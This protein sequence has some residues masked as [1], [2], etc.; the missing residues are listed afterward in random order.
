MNQLSVL[1]K[2]ASSLCNMRCR[3]CFYEDEAAHREVASYG[4]MENKVV[5]C[6]LMRIRNHFSAPSHINF[7]FQGGEPTLAGLDYFRYFTC[8]VDKM[9]PRDWS[10]SYSIQTNGYAINE[11]WCE[12]FKE[13][14][15]LVGLSQ[16]GPAA[17]HDRQRSDSDGKATFSRT[18]QA[19]TLMRRFE[20]PFNIV[21]VITEDA[22]QR[23][24]FLF[25]YYQKQHFPFVQ[26]IP[27]LSS[28]DGGTPDTRFL[29][30]RSY[31]AFMKS[32][33]KLWYKELKKGNYFSVRQFD[34]L[35]LMLCGQPPE[36]CGMLGCCT[37]Q[38]VVEAD[39][40]VYPCDFYVLDNYR[41]GNLADSSL[42]EI[43]SSGEAKRFVTDGTLPRSAA[44]SSAICQNCPV[45]R[46]CGGGC[47]RYR[48][49]YHAEPGYCP[50]QD[51]LSD[52]LLQ[53]QDA[54]RFLQKRKELL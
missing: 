13:H 1:V 15:F 20:I 30:P 47:R 14:D 4:I 2:P 54:A 35:I 44:S 37:L 31:A 51:F 42:S 43:L 17:I 3:Y 9:L 25:R 33:W 6:L 26:L 27:C 16:D 8:K 32:F 52:V 45:F 22:A 50:Y 48:S 41:C 34:N 5:D 49:F 18:A 40:S 46:L 29:T 39:G 12:F 21:T 11:K 53:L 36:Q 10:V 38:C 23:P 28:L 19:V 24:D 7:F